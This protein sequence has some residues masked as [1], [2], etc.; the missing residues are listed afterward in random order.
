MIMDKKQFA[1]FCADLESG[2]IRVAEKNGINF[3]YTDKVTDLVR[4]EIE[5]IY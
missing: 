5:K 4:N 1:D 2:R 3:F